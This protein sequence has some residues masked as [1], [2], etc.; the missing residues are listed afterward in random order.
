M[1]AAS[2]LPLGAAVT[3]W[4]ALRLARAGFFDGLASDGRTPLPVPVALQPQQ[5]LQ[6]DR[7]VRQ[8]RGGLCTHETRVVSGIACTTSERAVLDAVRDCD[9]V[10]AAVGV[11]DMALAA[12]VTT[13][14]RLDGYERGHGFRAGICRFR[15][16]AHLATERSLSP[17]ETVMRLIWILDAGLP[18]PLLNWPVLDADGRFLGQPDLL[19]V[20]LGVYGEFDGADHRER[21]QHRVDVARA[22]AFRS[23]GLEGFT[24]VGADLRDVRLVVTRMRAAV[25]RARAGRRG[26]WR[27]ADEAP[28]VWAK[29]SQPVA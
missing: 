2:R 10:R 26:S 17:M 25:E 22:E 4:A 1:E 29:W 21:E 6:L 11:M 9:D 24:I 5:R 20:E 18:T 12:G 13:R 15:E 27:V 8:I 3:G 16:A 23:V 19:S 7:A 28:P 14:S